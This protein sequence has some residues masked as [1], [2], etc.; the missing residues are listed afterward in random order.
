[1]RFLTVADRFDD[2][3]RKL[4]A[5]LRD[6]FVRAEFEATNDTLGKKIRNATTSK[7]PNVIVIGEREVED[8][9]VTLRRYGSREQRSMPYAE[10]KDRLLGAIRTRSDAGL[11]E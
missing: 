7:I 3:T 8:S 5:D 9:T 4:I 2:H 6:S 1:V 10:F 11:K